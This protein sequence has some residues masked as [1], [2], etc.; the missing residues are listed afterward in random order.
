MLTTKFYGLYNYLPSLLFTYLHL[1]N[2]YYFL[3]N[4]KDHSTLEEILI[5]TTGHDEITPL[6]ISSSSIKFL[7]EDKC[8]YPKSN[9]CIFELYLPIVHETYDKFKY[10]LNYG[11]KNGMVFGFS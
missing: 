1:F 9:T 2:S 6:E 10:H 11:F 7:H 8:P 4:E 3:E 5:F